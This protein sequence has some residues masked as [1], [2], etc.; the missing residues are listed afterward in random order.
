MIGEVIDPLAWFII[1]VS[2]MGP[3]IW[4]QVAKLFVIVIP[5]LAIG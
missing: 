4:F 5:T 2:C 1:V 3:D